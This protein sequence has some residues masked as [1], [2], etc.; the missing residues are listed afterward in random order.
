[1]EKHSLT[2]KFKVSAAEQV[3]TAFKD[4]RDRL[5]EQNLISLEQFTEYAQAQNPDLNCTEGFT[6]VRNV[7]YGRVADY[8]LTKQLEQYLIDHE[9]KS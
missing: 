9:P 2:F 4:L 5:K 3:K 1:M 8:D 7:F 6:H